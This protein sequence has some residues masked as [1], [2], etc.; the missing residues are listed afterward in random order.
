MRT[1]HGFREFGHHPLRTNGSGQE[2]WSDMYFVR[3][4][5]IEE[6]KRKTEDGHRRG[7]SKMENKKEG[8]RESEVENWKNDI[9]CW[10]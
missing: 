8:E 6:R 10:F 7:G 2:P 1:A 4:I 9:A 3:V 5:K